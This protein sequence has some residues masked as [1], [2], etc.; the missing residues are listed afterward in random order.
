MPAINSLLGKS[1]TSA[2]WQR[3]VVS[4]EEFERL[5]GVRIV[6]LAITGGGGLI[7]L[8]YQVVDPTK[9]DV[10]H[11]S[12]SAIIDQTTGVV[13]SETLMGHEHSGVYKAGVTYY[14]IYENPGNL[15][16]RGSVVNVLL[17]DV[18]M[19]DWVMH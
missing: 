12:V 4:K 2:Q 9:A 16:Q 8:R 17:G 7:D 5:T 15:V 10:I 6:Q 18:E 19:D 14:S 11:S 1:S 3:P 13:V